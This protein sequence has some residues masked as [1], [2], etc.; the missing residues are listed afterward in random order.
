[1][2]AEAARVL[3]PGGRVFV[4]V[5]VGECPVENPDL[6]GPAGA[7][8]TVPFE[9]DPVDL[10]EEAGFVGVRMSKFD[11]MPC[12]VRDGIGMREL[13]LEGFAPSAGDHGVVEVLYRG[14]FREVRDD[15]GRVFPRGRRVAVPLAVAERFR[16]GELATQFAVFESIAQRPAVLTACQS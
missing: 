5:L 11:T 14:P 10:L 1:V 12:F 13:Q 2:V 8:R 7:V 15:E 9:A 3:K 6:P 16:L 4:H